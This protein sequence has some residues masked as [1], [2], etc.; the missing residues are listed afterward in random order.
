MVS[1]FS[2]LHLSHRSPVPISRCVPPSLASEFGRPPDRFA[3]SNLFG[4]RL[5]TSPDL[6]RTPGTG[7]ERVRQTSRRSTSGMLRIPAQR[8]S[9]SQPPG[10]WPR[11]QARRGCP[12]DLSRGSHVDRKRG[13]GPKRSICSARIFKLTNS[14]GMREKAAGVRCERTHSRPA[15]LGKASPVCLDVQPGV[16]FLHTK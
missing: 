5:V 10:V 16:P 12:L 11:G 9:G 4:V 14:S 6:S 8:Q 2:H 7:G 15:R 13:A 3:K 1:V